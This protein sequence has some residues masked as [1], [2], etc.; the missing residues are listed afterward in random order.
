M[1]HEGRGRELEDGLLRNR[2]DTHGPYHLE[3][4]AQ[5]G[6]GL[7]V[8]ATH[9]RLIGRRAAAQPLGSPR[10]NPRDGKSTV[11][12][13]LSVL[14]GS[15]CQS[16]QDFFDADLRSRVSGKP[17]SNILAVSCAATALLQNQP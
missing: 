5:I 10:K 11:Q 16:V 14:L 4:I 8:A 3:T 2:R 6:E 17:F 9:Q 1:A 7:D 12:R 13:K 15:R